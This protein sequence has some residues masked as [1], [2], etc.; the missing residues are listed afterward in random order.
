M[1]LIAEL[2]RPEIVIVPI[3]DRFT[4]GPDT[5]AFAAKRF[6][7]DCAVIPCH[8]GSFPMLEPTADR[9]VAAM[10]GSGMQVIVPHKT[11]GVRILARP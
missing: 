11:V 5:A 9:F 10:E 6:F 2:H 7:P 4:M 3:G 8:Y 1:A